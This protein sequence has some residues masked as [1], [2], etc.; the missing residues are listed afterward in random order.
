MF[1]LIDNNEVAVDSWQA[2][3]CT[4][5]ENSQ[6]DNFGNENSAH[7]ITQVL[8]GFFN[9]FMRGAFDYISVLSKEITFNLS[10]GNAKN[11]EEMVL[12][13]RT[14][15]NELI[16]E[17]R[18]IAPSSL[19]WNNY[20]VTGISSVDRGMLLAV[21]AR[22]N[23]DVST[24]RTF[25][26]FGEYVLIDS[27]NN[28]YIAPDF[29]FENKTEKIES[30]HRVRSGEEY[31]YKWGEFRKFEMGVSFVNSSFK[32]VINSYWYDNTKLLFVQSGDMKIYSVQVSNNNLPVGNLIAPY[33][34]LFRG[35]IELESF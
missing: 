22:T 9:I 35:T 30:R 31:V 10:I 26:I 11:V 27:E 33:T 21:Y 32:S 14:N 1:R 13:I 23:L 7:R 15:S 28:I 2:F 29:D 6:I 12:S 8:S 24:T 34:N 16:S 3:R 5:A 4:V 17:L 19:G 25:D 20:E 18:S